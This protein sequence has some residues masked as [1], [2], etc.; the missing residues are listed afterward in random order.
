[1][2]NFTRVYVSVGHILESARGKKLLVL[3]SNSFSIISCRCHADFMHI[4]VCPACY[5]GDARDIPVIS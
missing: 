3:A 4:A 5:I 1:M 2:E